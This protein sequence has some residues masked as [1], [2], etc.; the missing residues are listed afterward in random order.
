MPSS[1][2]VTPEILCPVTVALD[3]QTPL[4]RGPCVPWKDGQP[5]YARR[6]PEEGVLYRVYNDTWRRS[7]PKSRLEAMAI[8]CPSSCAASFA[9]T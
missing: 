1:P 5:E 9:T 3:S 8:R 6:R 7:L 2:L 4:S